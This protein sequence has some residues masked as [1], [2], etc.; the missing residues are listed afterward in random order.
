[1][2]DPG[3]R[4]APRDSDDSALACRRFRV[5]GRVQGVFFRASTQTVARDLGLAGQA[6]N[7]DDGSVEIVASGPRHALDALQRWLHDG[8]AM[9]RVESVTA[10]EEPYRDISG[11]T[12]R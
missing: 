10:D 9:A 2:A 7:C 6:V 8:P 4:N 1:M 11:F 5:R 3:N 12:T